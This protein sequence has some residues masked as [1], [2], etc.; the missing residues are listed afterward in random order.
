MLL[1]LPLLLI[2]VP[3]K[4]VG[5]ENVGGVAGQGKA[6]VSQTP[7]PDES[8]QL[9]QQVSKLTR[10]GKYDEAIPLAE[11]AVALREKALGAEHLDV[12]RS[13][14]D[15]AVLYYNKHDYSHAEPLLLR[16]LS[17]REKVLG[18]EH[19]T[20]AS[21]LHNLAVLYHD[22]GDY[23]RAE[24][25]FVRVLA[26][27]EK[28]LGTEH[29]TVAASLFTLA[30]FYRG[31]EEYAR[32]EPLYRRA[33]AIREKAL[34]AEHLT[35][36]ATLNALAIMYYKKGD[37]G[38]AQPLYERALAIREKALGSEHTDVAG[39]V[40]NL[41][42][43]YLMKGDYAHAEPLYQRAL[44]MQE[45]AFG[46]ESS[47]VADKVDHLGSLYE[48]TGDYA[49]AEAMY[50]REL[51]ISEK[52]FGAES[53]GVADALARLA[54]LSIEEADYAR[55][56]PLIERALAINEKA[57]GAESH[58][59]AETL[60]LLAELY[61]AKGDYARAESLLQRALSIREKA[62]GSENPAV[63][64]TLSDLASLYEGEGKAELAIQAQS[65]GN[66]VSEH[67]LALILST[68]SEKQKLLYIA[69]LTG[70]L[71]SAISLHTTLAPESAQAARLALTTILRRKGRALDA[72]ADQIAALRRRLDPQDQALLDQ[73]SAARAQLST[74][75]LGGLGRTPPDEYQATI[76]KLEA[77]VER[78]EAAVSARSAEFRVGS[79]PVTVEQA[80][81][82]IPQGAALVEIASYRPFDVKAKKKSERF[83]ARRYVAY[84]LKREGEP[85][86]A[87]L[88]DAAGIDRAVKDFRG[89]LTAP[90]GADAKRGDVKQ[91][92][93]AL[94]ELVMRPVRRLLGDA[95]HI[96]LSPDGALNL[97][98]F[99]ALVDEQS[100]YLLETYS[101]TYLTSGRDLL[102]LQVKSESRQSPVVLANPAFDL[103]DTPTAQS[104]AAVEARGQRDVDFAQIEWPPLKGTAQEAAALKTILSGAR[105]LTEGE[106]T[107][108]ALK[109]VAAPRI[110]HVSTHGFFLPD[111]PEDNNVA[112]AR[113][114]IRLSAGSAPAVARADNLLLRSGLALAGANRL[115]GG[116]GEDG[117]LTAL[118]AAGLDL[119]GTQLVVLSAC[120]T[121][122]GSVKSGDGVY[123]LRRA[124]A[125]S[126][127]QV[128]SLWKVDD[129]ATRDLMVAYY[130]RLQAGE[131]RTEALRQVQLEMIGNARQGEAGQGRGLQ[132]GKGEGAG[133][134][135]PYFWASFIQSGDWRGLD[136]RQTNVRK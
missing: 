112:D 109:Q 98:P 28:A 25:A 38:S 22:K 111:K 77:E 94:D 65:R 86:W 52:E 64:A 89:V 119:W 83:G 95:R 10:E 59:V 6:N 99:A 63:A 116:G 110:L 54:K 123:G 50:R 58:D 8:A 133:R 130:K 47:K 34:G 114:G 103:F 49:R 127:S 14:N 118:E 131:G 45:K 70:E 67:N 1:A 39:T 88:G 62:L 33:L 108:S 82:A 104:A 90:A 92:A 43:V 18:P 75:A 106:A 41:A 37:L 9:D 122:V 129:A 125:G 85:L 105:V 121:G 55:A 17:I 31:R 96:L 29:L 102:R 100:R 56:E 107:E 120:E 53:P 79:Q 24:P 46:A 32:A 117:I 93:R 66:D 135:H 20:V 26:I 4:A 84:V 74:L 36:A 73:L 13:L 15:L 2:G 19:R 97:I 40:G 16:A 57:R 72:M 61:Q 76:R 27:R 44:A 23:V 128:M 78:L 51:A 81:K 134:S 42:S 136:A 69:T 91:T 48:T 30:E 21:S 12:A 87:D 126:E 11:R 71:Y 60:N 101:I 68:G 132:M 124:L 113:R 115:Q 35:V 3:L 5:Q 7:E 80:Q